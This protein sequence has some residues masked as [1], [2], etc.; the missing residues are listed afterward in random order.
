[1]V[2]GQFCDVFPPE[3]DG[4]GMVV[5]SYVEELIS[6]GHQCFY[7]SP[8]SPKSQS[9]QPFP[10]FHYMSVKLA[11]GVY[12]AG[13]PVLDFPFRKKLKEIHFDIIHAHSPFT[14]GREAMRVAKHQNIPLIGTFHTKYYDDFYIKTHSKLLAKTGLRFVL[15]FYNTCDEVWA[16]NGATAEVLRKYGYKKR[17]EIMPNGTNLWFPDEKDRGLAAERFELAKKTVLLFVGQLNWKKNIRNI[18]KAVKIYSESSDDFIMVLAGQG[19][20]EYEI[21]ELVC[22]LGLKE[23]ILFTGHIVDRALL[24]SLYAKADLLV[25]PSLYDNAPMVV[26]EA[27]AAGTPALLIKDSCAAEGIMHESN[28][29]LCEDNP[30]SIAEGITNA[31]PLSKKAGENARNTIPLPWSSVIEQALI[32]YQSLIDKKSSAK[33][34]QSH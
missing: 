34:E 13:I 25:F 28:G 20:D 6:H 5:K 18:I 26:R 4:V 22:K 19:P 10:T 14:A 24:M 7:I 30:V 17:I 9:N 27:A 15:D 32:R 21:K 31:L 23:K 16:V 1:M 2:I 12:R 29:F 11:G 3:T 33:A 8:D